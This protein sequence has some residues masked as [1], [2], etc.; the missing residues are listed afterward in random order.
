MKEIVL[1]EMDTFKWC[2]GNAC[3]GNVDLEDLDFIEED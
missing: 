3:G 1:E 2:I